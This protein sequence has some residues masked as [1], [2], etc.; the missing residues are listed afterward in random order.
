M[1][2]L[3]NNVWSDSSPSR[4]APGK[5]LRELFTFYKGV[6]LRVS[7]DS[8]DKKKISFPQWCMYPDFL[9]VQD[10]T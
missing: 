5:E 9:L 7:L 4:F 10:L 1:L 2:T 3:E 8:L 6:S